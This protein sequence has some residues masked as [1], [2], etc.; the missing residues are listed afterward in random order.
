MKGYTMRRL[1]VSLDIDSGTFSGEQLDREIAG[2]S[3]DTRS[4][5]AGDV[6]F[7]LRGERF[8]GADFVG[9]A[10]DA[11]AL[12]AVVNADSLNKGLKP[13]ITGGNRVV[14]V[15]DTERALGAAARGYRVLFTGRVVCVT[16]TTGKT[17]VKEMIRAVLACRFSVHWTKG[18]LN[19]QIGLPLSVF[20]LEDR[21]D[22]AVFELGMSAPG[23]IA[24]LAG[25]ACPDIGVVLNVGPAH[26]AFFTN[27]DQIA[28][29]KTELLESLGEHGIAVVNG[30]DELIMARESRC[31]GR[32]VRFGVDGPCEY[33]AE[34]IT[35]HPDGCASF[36]VEGNR[37]T[38]VVPGYHNVYNALAAY[39]VGR[40]MDVAGEDAAHALGEVV[41]PSMRLERFERD[42]VL[43]INDSY[44]ANPLSMKAAADVLKH[45]EAKPGGRKIAVLGDMLELGA[46]SDR[47][48]RDVG[49][50]FGSLGLDLLCVVGESAGF[51]AEGA[52]EGGMN[53]RAVRRFHTVE[54]AR[55]FTEQIQQPGDVVFVKGSRALGME[56][57]IARS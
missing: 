54:E 15:K 5:E 51:Y 46:I 37:I 53:R 29:S 25:I 10:L 43:Y 40:V 23:E 17:T 39:A 28:D 52:V 19:N 34:Y 18:N 31:R 7:A 32:I 3:T 8:D 12:L 26:M 50:L 38:L 4:L 56:K 11:G 57:I 33:R 24:Y 13:L 21:H 35:L 55:A 14:C 2:V 16:G 36:E 20:G 1:L 49:A 42:G 6:F 22:C 27:I 9:R 47:A 30:D 45:T 48:H 41:A 44:N